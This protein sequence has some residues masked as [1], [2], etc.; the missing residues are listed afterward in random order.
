MRTWGLV[1]VLVGLVTLSACTK[2]LA[3]AR[4]APDVQ[5]ISRSF[6]ANANDTYY[7]VRWALNEA[8]YPVAGEDLASGIITTK[9]V[10]VTSDSHYIELFGRRD[11]GVTNSYYQLDLRIGYDNGRATVQIAARAKT[12]AANFKSSGI[13]ERKV[14]DFIGSYLRIGEP[15]ITNLGVSE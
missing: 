8:G 3:N 9:W 11:F 7:A 2:P 14:L 10:P 12:L 13:E 4:V 5:Y 1:M 15:E 6:P